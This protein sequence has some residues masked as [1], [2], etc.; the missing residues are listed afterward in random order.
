MFSIKVIFIATLI[1]LGFFTFIYFSIK[2][3]EMLAQ[4]NNEIH[5]LVL[6][7]FCKQR[8]IEQAVNNICIKLG[9]DAVDVFKLSE[10]YT[11]FEAGDF[12]II[13]E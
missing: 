9:Y 12:E 1:K 4:I 8:S 7:E 10:L 11:R 6:H 3:S 2:F 13:E 5:R